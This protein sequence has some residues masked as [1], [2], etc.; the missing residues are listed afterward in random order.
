MA[1]EEGYRSRAAYKLL[2]IDE[3]F[4]IFNAGA[5]VIDLGAAP[6]GWTQV[7]LVKVKQTGKVIAVDLAPMQEVEGAI[8]LQQNFLDLGTEE[9]LK[10]HIEDDVDVIISDMAAPS[11]GHPATDH[12]R[13]LELCE[14][15]LEFAVSVLKQGGSFVCKV[16]RGGSEQE[17]LKKTKAYFKLAKS[18]KPKASRADSSEIYIVAQNFYGN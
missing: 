18:Y 12:L 2:E 10:Q 7:A 6:G 3:K 1:R 5:T 9:L 14:T 8:F 15:T 17:L 16:L 11:C 13:I 4:K